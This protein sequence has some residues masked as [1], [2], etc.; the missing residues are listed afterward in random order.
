MISDLG[1]TPQSPS[2]SLPSL[3]SI[4]AL[5][6]HA[7]LTLWLVGCALVLTIM[8]W[9][10]REPLANLRPPGGLVGQYYSSSDWTGTPLIQ[11]T[12]REISDKVLANTP[13]LR[14]LTSFSIEWSGYLVTYHDAVH[15]FA[16]KTDDG[17]WMWIDDQLVIDNGGL[18]PVRNVTSELFLPRGVHRFRLRYLQ[19]GDEYS[20]LLGQA[21]FRGRF[22][23]PAPLTP[24][25]MS[26]TAYRVRELW[27]LGFVAIWYVALVAVSVHVIRTL[28]RYSLFATLIESLSDRRFLA[29]ALVGMAFSIAHIGYG[30]PALES[31]S[32]D[33][34]DPLGTLANSEY[35]FA[36]WNLR[37]PPLHLSVIALVLA[38]FELAAHW[39]GLNM[40]DRT[41]AGMMFIVIR[42]LSVVMLFATL[43]FTFDIARRR[44]SAPAGY[45]AV[46][47]LASSP[48]VVYFGSLANLEIPHLFWMALSFWAWLQLGERRSTSAAVLFGASVGCSIAAKDQAYGYYLL[49]PIALVG[50]FARGGVGARRLISAVVDKRVLAV[51]AATLIAFSL[52]H[53]LPWGWDRFVARLYSVIS[54]D[55]IPFRLFDR[56]VDGFVGLSIATV[57]SF[58]WA[59]GAPLVATATGGVALSI[60]TGR[61]RLLAPLLAPGVTY[62]AAFICVILFVY[63][64][65][66][67]AMLPGAALLGGGFLAWVIEMASRT[68]RR[69]LIAV[70]VGLLVVASLNAAAQNVIFYNDPRHDA[71]KWLARNVPCGSSV[72]VTYDRQYVPDLYC[73]DVWDLIP[74]RTLTMVRFPDRFVLNPAYAHRFN[75]A[76]AGRL[77]LT[78][79]SRGE[80]GYDLV[81]RAHASAPRWAPMFWEERFQNGREEAF[82]ILDKPLHAIEVWERRGLRSSAQADAQ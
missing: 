15:R 35:G 20:L 81:Y 40:W 74:S 48:V 77:F 21:A 55:S 36:D 65:F 4:A 8:A 53:R 43:L 39:F 11:R 16:T 5:D 28:G 23:H 34:L 9:A 26:Y 37:W 70:P 58:A 14:R 22:L 73:R 7:R 68:N 66:L 44:I 51:G 19:G 10:F 56:S 18:H 31:L 12:D 33:E 27:P 82:T 80:L 54:V 2:R 17:S 41:V 13:E 42:S 49:A 64:R 62:F 67:I 24:E 47:L 30:M 71:A 29:V 59:A 3:K 76:P 25:P 1:S 45:F 79:L 38:P 60:L 69:W 63:D 46:A 32:G 61:S 75:S 57:K 78:R 6:R 52:G 72:G 50:L